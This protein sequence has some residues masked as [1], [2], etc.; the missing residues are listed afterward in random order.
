MV[1]STVLHAAMFLGPVVIVF[2][3][4]VA[5]PLL[6]AEARSTHDVSQSALSPASDVTGVSSA[7][8]GLSGRRPTS[9]KQQE[10]SRDRGLKSASGGVL[11]AQR[12]S[13]TS[14]LSFAAAAAASTYARHGRPVFNS[15]RPK[16]PVNRLPPSSTKTQT[17]GSKKQ[18]DELHISNATTTAS[19]S[20]NAQVINTKSTSALVLSLAYLPYYGK[21][22]MV[23]K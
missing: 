5:A 6:A 11:Q 16:M 18:S 10:R 21:I 19:S 7:G 17:T 9:L 13:S 15:Q 22:A 20:P 8:I 3:G 23:L 12:K 1:G 14:L 4:V 2:A